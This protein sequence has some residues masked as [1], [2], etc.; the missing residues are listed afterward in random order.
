M[1]KDMHIEYAESD[2]KGRYSMA[3]DGM[4]EQAEI[5]ISKATPHLVIADH[6]FVPE[7]MRGQGVAIALAERLISDARRK[8]QRIVPLCPF[9]RAYA[10]K[11]SKE[12]NDVI[13]W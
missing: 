8:N 4:R 9:L 7:A 6:T 12:L 11:H 1:P 2:T 13:Q 3:I 10:E 5:T